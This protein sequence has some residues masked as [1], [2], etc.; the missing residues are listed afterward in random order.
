MH[1]I[2]RTLYE[3]CK[4]STPINLKS[5]INTI[6]YDHDLKIRYYKKYNS[7]NDIYTK[8]E[9]EYYNLFFGSCLYTNSYSPSITPTFYNYNCITFDVYDDNYN[10]WFKLEIQYSKEEYL[11]VGLYDEDECSLHDL[12]NTNINDDVIIVAFTYNNSLMAEMNL[13]NDNNKFIHPD[14]LLETQIYGF[15]EHYENE[16]KK[17]DKLLEQYEERS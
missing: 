12:Y 15:K 16:V 7:L 2:V 5:L 3:M 4:N 9:T 10:D 6:Y 1:E 11:K 17:N 8:I 13:F 14:S